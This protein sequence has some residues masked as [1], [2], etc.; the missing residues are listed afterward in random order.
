VGSKLR[1]HF[2]LNRRLCQPKDGT[3]HINYRKCLYSSTLKT[4]AAGNVHEI[5]IFSIIIELFFLECGYV[6]PTIT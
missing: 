4:E 1:P 2:T 6:G 3:S 5:V